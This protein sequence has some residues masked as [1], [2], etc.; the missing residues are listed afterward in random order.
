MAERI[1]G[2]EQDAEQRFDHVVPDLTRALEPVDGKGKQI[3]RIVGK[4]SNDLLG[5]KHAG[6]TDLLGG[7]IEKE[8]VAGHDC[9]ET[10]GSVWGDGD[11]TMSQD[12]IEVGTFEHRELVFV[13]RL[14]QLQ[15][16]ERVVGAGAEHEND[17]GWRVG[18]EKAQIAQA[19]WVFLDLIEAVNV[20]NRLRAAGGDLGDRSS[21]V[22]LQ[23][24]ATVAGEVDIGQIVLQCEAGDQVAQQTHLVVGTGVKWNEVVR[25]RLNRLLGDGFDRQI[26][27]GRE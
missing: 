1:A 22:I 21:E 26:G 17:A 23:G 18:S 20:D 9:V 24:R 3:G 7:E 11:L 4:A 25:D 14:E 15:R 13:M 27:V 16:L 19:A 8:R 2:G 10:I 5:R 12:K 6:R